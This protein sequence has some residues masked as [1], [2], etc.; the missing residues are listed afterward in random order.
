MK[1]KK[2]EQNFSKSQF[3][4]DTIG[5]YSVSEPSAYLLG[6]K[7]VNRQGKD[8]WDNLIHSKGGKVWLN[9]M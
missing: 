4:K 9:Y 2:V 6:G 5:V 3:V 8:K 1:L 7:N